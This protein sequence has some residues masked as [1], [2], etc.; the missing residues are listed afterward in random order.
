[1]RLD[2]NMNKE[3][4]LFESLKLL[5]AYQ[6][7]NKQGSANQLLDLQTYQAYVARIDQAICLIDLFWPEF[8]EWEGLILRK[9]AFPEDW[10]RFRET[11]DAAKWTPS[12]MEYMLNRVNIADFFLNDPDRDNVDLSVYTSIAQKVAEMWE[13]KIKMLYPDRSIE[14]SIV[15]S[16]I[17]PEVYMF[18]NR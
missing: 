14:V 10:S 3:L 6:M 18:V 16:D 11:A 7:W 8:I 13:C 2:K 15:H 4:G 1:M 9:S 12:D 5:P 17:D